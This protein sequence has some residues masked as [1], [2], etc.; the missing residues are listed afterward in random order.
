YSWLNVSSDMDNLFTF[1]SY[2]SYS[3]QKIQ[4]DFGRNTLQIIESVRLKEPPGNIPEDCETILGTLI[5]EFCANFKNETVIVIDD[6]HNIDFEKNEEWIKESFRFLFE[7]IPDN[8]HIVI[9]SREYPVFSMARLSA[10]RKMY[11]MRTEE[12][13]FS[14]NEAA[15]LL[16]KIYAYKYNSESLA[17]LTENF[18]GW[19][20]GIHLI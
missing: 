9:I 10:K 13:G 17:F 4:K 5:N 6:L 14:E 19:I 18:G 8:L 1:F 11:E 2:L 20:T 3:L 16:E 15:E 12:L 7:N